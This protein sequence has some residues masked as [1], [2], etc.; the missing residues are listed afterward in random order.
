CDLGAGEYVKGYFAKATRYDYL[1]TCSRGHS[2]P[3]IDGAYQS[4]GAEFKGTMTYENGIVTV[5]MSDAYAV[6]VKAVRA[7]EFGEKGI[8]L[9]D[10]FDGATRVT[11]RFITTIVPE[12][13]AD[14]VW[15]KNVR[16]TAGTP[17]SVQVRK[18]TYKA[19][20]LVERTVYMIDYEAEQ[21]RS[22]ALKIELV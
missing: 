17:W 19:Q 7:F 4:S 9:K 8:L 3:I 14:G 2:V 16:L 5:D 20:S 6:D 15:I 13:K 1:S 10:E 21:T 12:V 11:E 22:F 18:E